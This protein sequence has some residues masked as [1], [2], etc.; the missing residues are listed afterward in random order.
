LDASNGGFRNPVDLDQD[1]LA[2][3]R[4]ITTP[5]IHTPTPSIRTT[6]TVANYPMTRSNSQSDSTLHLHPIGNVVVDS[7]QQFD[8]LGHLGRNNKVRT[9]EFTAIS[10]SGEYAAIVSRKKIRLFGI[11]SRPS[12]IASGSFGTKKNAS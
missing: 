12:L 1:Q 2:L 4:L 9:A 10:P 6:P 3:T 7:R 8:L 11:S 5:K